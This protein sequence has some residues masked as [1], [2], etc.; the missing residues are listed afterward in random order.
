VQK[1]FYCTN[2]ILI[3][4]IIVFAWYEI[5]SDNSVSYTFFPVSILSQR[6]EASVVTVHTPAV[7]QN[8]TSKTGNDFIIL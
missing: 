2:I 1:T 8:S 3:G 6:L 7:K 5:T 4:N